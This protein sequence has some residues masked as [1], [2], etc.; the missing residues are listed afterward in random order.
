MLTIL[1]ASFLIAGTTVGGGF[2]ALPTVI[3][4]IG[5]V[6]SSIAFVG[7]WCYFLFQSW[8]VVECLFYTRAI[9]QQRRQEKRNE[10]QEQNDNDSSSS[11]L[12]SS[13]SPGIVSV[14]NQIFGTNGKFITVFLLALLMEATLVS[15]IS[16]AGTLLLPLSSSFLSS[17]YKMNCAAVSISIAS[18][19]FT[20]SSKVTAS[21]NSILTFLFCTMAILLFGVGFPNATWSHLFTAGS[22]SS[23]S[24]WIAT[25]PKAIPTILQLLVYAE[26]LPTVCTLCDYNLPIIRKAILIGSIV[27]CIL[28]IGW[29]ALG[30]GLVPPSSG[31]VG[32]V[33]RA[34]VDPVDVLLQTNNP[35]QAPLFV[36]AM[37]AIATTIIGSYL[38]LQSMLHDLFSSNHHHQS[39]SPP[40]KNDGNGTNNAAIKKGGNETKRKWKRQSFAAT[41][42]VTPALLIAST[43]PDLFLQAIDFA[44]SYPVLLLWGI[45]PPIV[46][47]LQRRRF[48]N[49]HTTLV[50]EKEENSNDKR[51]NQK[52]GKEKAA[53]KKQR[54]FLP[55]W[56]LWCLT[57]VSCGLFSM[58]AIPDFVFLINSLKSLFLSHL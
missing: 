56:S 34:V 4:P 1:N 3:A 27:P 54:Q 17:S 39:S 45:F 22:S 55:M 26:I 31:V 24:G 40:K 44:G 25:L 18:L 49:M 5:F 48:K 14:A 2:L 41:S 46:A 33:G 6:P 38:A 9:Q 50:V 29:V 47:I 36:L 15:Q 58:S 10:E 51:K 28:E 53:T 20:Q 52:V 35:V 43:S 30:I 42:I 57:F 12:S 11:S 37:T 13:S 8:T 16:R 23:S 19:V 7:V 32:V 21:I